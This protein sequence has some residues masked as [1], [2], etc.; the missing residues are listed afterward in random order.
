[1]ADRFRSTERRRCPRT[2]CGREVLVNQDGS[3]RA[4]RKPMGTKGYL[5]D[6]CRDPITGKAHT[7]PKEVPSA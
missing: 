7:R 3:L 1:M 6:V 2:N 4:H 5:G